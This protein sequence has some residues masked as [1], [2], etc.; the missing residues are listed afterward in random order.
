VRFEILTH[1]ENIKMIR[2]LPKDSLCFW[3]V[4]IVKGVILL[5]L[6]NMMWQV[7]LI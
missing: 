2:I 3:G 4:G 7:H 5:V 1:M 6:M